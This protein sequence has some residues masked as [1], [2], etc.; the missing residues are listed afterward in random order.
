MVP[1]I[2]MAV[3]VCDHFRI[4]MLHHVVRFTLEQIMRMK[5]TSIGI[6]IKDQ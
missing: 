6:G 4:R 2:E 5:V 1:A 3:S